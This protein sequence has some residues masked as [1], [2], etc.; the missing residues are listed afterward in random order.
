M[1]VLHLSHSDGGSGAGRAAYRIHTSF[2]NANVDSKMLVSRKRTSD[3]SVETIARNAFGHQRNRLYEYIEAKVSRNL[4]VNASEFLSFPRFS[5]LDP[6]K[7]L[8][9]QEA[10]VI[11][12]YWVNGACL[13]PEKLATLAKP[14][15]WRFSER[16]YVF[17][18]AF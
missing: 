17:L 12:A 14:L 6:P 3:S 2:Q 9:V 5:L 10:E 1:K 8:L 11:L 16:V 18:P 15:I 4:A 13:T 7:N